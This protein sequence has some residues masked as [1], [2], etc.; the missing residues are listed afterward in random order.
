LLAGQ[1]LMKFA[2]SKFN[3]NLLALIHLFVQASKDII[4]AKLETINFWM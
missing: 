2:L 4:H 3:V 1:N